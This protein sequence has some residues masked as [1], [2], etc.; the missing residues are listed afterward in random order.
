MKRTNWLKC[1]SLLIL[2]LTAVVPSSPCAEKQT[3][4]S[5]Q[6][7]RF[8]F[9]YPA[10]WIINPSSE[11]DIRVKV[12]APSNS[13]AAECAMVIK[14]HPRATSAK[15][16]DIDEIFLVPPTTSELEEVLRQR[17]GAVKVSK[18]SAG[19]L[20]SRPAHFARVQYNTGKDAYASGRVVMTATP[21]L[22]WALSCS[23][24]GRTPNEAE[25]S[26]QLW[27][28]DMNNLVSSFKFE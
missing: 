21:G 1:L 11:A 5:N 9:K 4:Y 25:K 28:K 8:S 2:S 6:E 24:L 7:F 3:S 18:A 27:E 16:S 13:L 22:T 19:S 14:R 20:H 12:A 10:S 26:F 23:G 15:Q 17:D